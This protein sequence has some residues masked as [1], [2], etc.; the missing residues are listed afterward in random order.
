MDVTW[1]WLVAGLAFG[2]TLLGLAWKADDLTSKELREDLSLHLLCVEPER[3]GMAVRAWPRHFAAL[4]DRVFGSKHLS[5]RCFVRSCIAS[6]GALAVAV[7]VYAH[8]APADWTYVKHAVASGE[9]MAF[10]W[11]FA[12]AWKV[13]VFFAAL[14]L[15]PDYLSLLETR[16]VIR[17]L[18]S[19]GSMTGQLAWL[20]LDFAA[21]LAIFLIPVA[22][23]GMLEG[24]PAFESARNVLAAGMLSPSV[25]VDGRILAV[26]LWT[27]FATSVWVWIYLAAQR[28]TRLASQIRRSVAF[29]QYALPIEERPLRSVGAVMALLGCLAVW[30]VMAP[31]GARTDPLDAEPL[32]PQMVEVPS[33]TFIMGSPDNEQGRW[34]DEGPRRSVRVEGFLIGRYEVTFDEYDRFARATGRPLPGGFFYGREKRPVVGVTWHDARAYAYW[35]SKHTGKRYRLPSE[36]EWEYAARARTT[37]SRYWGEAPEQG[38]CVHE[39]V[40]DMHN[41]EVLRTRFE[42]TINW[43]AH[44]CEDGYAFSAPV[45]SFKHNDFGLHDVLGNVAEWVDDCWHDSYKGAPEEARPAWLKGYGGDCASRVVRGGSWDVNPQRVRSAYRLRLTARNRNDLLGFRLAQDP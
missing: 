6:L 31:L 38:Q 44:P 24:M 11:Y 28:L 7:I 20:T 12:P 36:A 30:V 29:L 1:Q 16:F 14:N 3:V 17:R 19:V 21:T 41:E 26:F 13:G 18:A 37:T 9:R 39:N 4:F 22:A 43:E 33:G 23:F 34:A 5:V 45:G 8:A 27:T 40:F 2:G 35:L 42:Q 10:F 15:I 32:M 25:P